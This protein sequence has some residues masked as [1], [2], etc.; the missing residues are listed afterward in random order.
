M[1]QLTTHSYIL[2]LWWNLNSSQKQHRCGTGKLLISDLLASLQ[3]VEQGSGSK[4]QQTTDASCEVEKKGA[5]QKIY[6]SSTCSQ[7]KIQILRVCMSV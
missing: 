2:V 5:V 3:R 4:P 6:I 1:S 7:K